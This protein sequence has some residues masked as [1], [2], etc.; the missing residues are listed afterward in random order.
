[1]L[2]L[3]RLNVEDLNLLIYF[4]TVKSLLLIGHFGQEMTKH[5]TDYTGTVKIQTFT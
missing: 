3:Y 2:A 1:M 4:F 5:N